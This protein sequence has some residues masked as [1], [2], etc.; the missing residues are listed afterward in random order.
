MNSRRNLLKWLA[1]GTVFATVVGATSSEENGT[2]KVARASMQLPS[3]AASPLRAEA[4]LAT[5]VHV[6]LERLARP[7]AAPAAAFTNAFGTT[8]WYV[9]P[10]PPPPAP[11]PPPPVPTAPPMPF[12]YLGRY[13]DALTRLVILTKGERMYTVAEGDVI[14]NMYRIERVTTSM[15]EMTY[16]PLNIKQTLGTGETI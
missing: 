11:P 3:G 14:E 10:P 8:T 15:V 5:Q 1:L 4:R 13:E 7:K 16:M 12:T 9:P 2:P 6:E